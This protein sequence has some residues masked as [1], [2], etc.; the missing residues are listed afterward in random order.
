VC[1]G[2]KCYGTSQPR[3]LL[4]PCLPPQVSQRRAL[5]WCQATGDL[6]YF[7]TSAKG[8]VNVGQAFQVIGSTAIRNGTAD[9][10]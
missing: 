9:D 2:R 1:V 3:P 6:P 8:D 7:E 4:R 10:A 5:E